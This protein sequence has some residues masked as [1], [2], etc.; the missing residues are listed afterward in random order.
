M[1]SSGA[2]FPRIARVRARSEF[3][4]VFKQA[5][6]TGDPLLSLHWLVSDTPARL[7]LAVSRKVDPHAVGRNR[8]KR[9]LREQFRMLRA[10]LA[11][12]DYVCVARAAAAKADAHALRAAFVNVLHRAGALPPSLANGTMRDEIPSHTDTPASDAG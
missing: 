11:H 8:I 9:A 7:G 12:G 6:R 10:Q 5:R 4:A 2:R 1:T 3:D